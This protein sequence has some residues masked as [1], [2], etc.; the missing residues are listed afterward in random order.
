MTGAGPSAGGPA[1]VESTRSQ[2][3][4]VTGTAALVLTALA[5]AAMAVS[6]FAPLTISDVLVALLLGLVVGQVQPISWL[7]PAVARLA[8]VVL[9]TGVA[10]LGARLSVDVILAT[11][12]EA[13][14]LIL[15]TMA[16]SFLLVWLVGRRFGLPG[17]LTTLI[18]L[19]MAVCGNTAIAA[20]APVIGARARHISYAIATITIFGTTA[21]IAY[22]LLGGALAMPSSAF[23][24]WSGIS[25]N[26]T[27]QVVAA[28]AAYSN[29]AL[30]VATVVKL[31]RNAMIAPAVAVLAWRHRSQTLNSP[32]ALF[33]KALPLFVIAF[34]GLATLRTIGL[35]TDELA[36]AATTM[37][38]PLIVA[39][40]AGIGFST[41]VGELSQVGMW[42][43]LLGLVAGVSVAALTLFIVLVLGVGW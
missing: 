8:P 41:N 26:D 21:V 22:P 29:S 23:G 35:L 40:I 9:R 15:A 2:R 25:I 19:G 13:L 5:A 4:L 38:A 28:G 30:I 27:S 7:G 34:L 6:A 3:A 39:A 42:P 20:A 11:G 18:A 32:W 16:S 10:L 31:V 14:L 37:S 1:H 12:E 24:V 36:G 33:T 17:D 43:L